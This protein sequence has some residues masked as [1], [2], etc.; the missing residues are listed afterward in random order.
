MK[1]KEV[2]KEELF[3]CSYGC[4][5][6]AAVLAVRLT[7]KVLGKDSV[8]IVRPQGLSK[9]RLY[10]AL[11]DKDVDNVSPVYIF[12]AVTSLRPK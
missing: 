8:F 1:L 7:L 9:R 3:R 12:P 4:A 11:S 6:C 5:G 2:S 10:Q